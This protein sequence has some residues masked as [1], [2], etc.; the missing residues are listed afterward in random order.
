ML[1]TSM[2]VL[3]KSLMNIN[4]WVNSELLVLLHGQMVCNQLDGNSNSPCDKTASKSESS[5]ITGNS[6]A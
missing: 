1:F 2:L 3:V 4:E 5:T 6:T